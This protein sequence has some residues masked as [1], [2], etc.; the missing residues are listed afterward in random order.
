MENLRFSIQNDGIPPLRFAPV[1]MTPGR[2]YLDVDRDHDAFD[3]SRQGQGTLHRDG[4]VRRAVRVGLIVIA[5][6]P[7]E[8]PVLNDIPVGHKVALVDMNPGD[9]VI[10][11]GTD[12]GKVVTPIKKGEHVHVHNLKTKRW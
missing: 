11:Y 5:A 8:E 6:C 7:E 12:I 1:G 3:A 10:K 4:F 9:T 2:S